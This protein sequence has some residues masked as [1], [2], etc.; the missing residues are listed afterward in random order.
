M[1]AAELG[2]DF[3]RRWS[4]GLRSEIWE[5]LEGCAPMH[6]LP[7]QKMRGPERAGNSVVG[8]AWEALKT[9]GYCKSVVSHTMVTF[10]I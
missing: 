9:Q 7:F 2:Q 5:M 3:I 8:C 1:R 6:P 10:H 4:G